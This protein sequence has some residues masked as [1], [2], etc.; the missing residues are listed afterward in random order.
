[1][2]AFRN[3]WNRLRRLGTKVEDELY[4][5]SE[6]EERE[7]EPRGRNTIIAL[8]NAFLTL[9]KTKEA[10][11]AERVLGLLGFGGLLWWLV[12]DRGMGIKKA[13]LRIAATTFAVVWFLPGLIASLYTLAQ[14]LGVENLRRWRTYPLLLTFAAG[15]LMAFRAVFGDISRQ[16]LRPLPPPRVQPDR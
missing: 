10:T 14:N 6:E 3:A 5:F 15:G 4:E 1:M 12:G 7:E 13:P 2:T 9:W 11:P 16:R 8:L